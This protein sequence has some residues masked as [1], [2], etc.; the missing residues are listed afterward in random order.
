[1]TSSTAG[2]YAIPDVPLYAAAKHAVSMSMFKLNI[3]I[4]MKLGYWSYPLTW[5]AYGRAE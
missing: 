3:G 4:L 2:I 1:M 5:Y